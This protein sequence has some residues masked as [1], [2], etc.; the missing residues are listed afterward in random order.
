MSQQE[1]AERIGV[2]ANTVGRWE[3]GEAHPRGRIYARM[4]EVYELEVDY[5][6]PDTVGARLTKQISALEA[7]IEDL[8]AEV[9]GLRSGRDAEAQEAGPGEGDAEPTDQSG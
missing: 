4:L 8:E 3:R 9:Q 5:G 6:L 7:R 2:Q 1:A